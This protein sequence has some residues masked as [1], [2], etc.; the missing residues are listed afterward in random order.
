MIGEFSFG[1]IDGTGDFCTGLEYA[2]DQRNRGECYTHY[3]ETALDDVRCIGAHWFAYT[4]QPTAGRR[5]D[6]ENAALG[7]VDVA[8]T[9]YYELVNA[10]R[11]LAPRMYVYRF[12]KE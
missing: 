9:P 1:A 10:V 7:F 2:A 5:N 11:A 6:A 4:S 8:D 3:I 12:G